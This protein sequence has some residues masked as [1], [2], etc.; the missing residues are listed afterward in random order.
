MKFVRAVLA[1]SVLLVLN[2]CV[3]EKPSEQPFQADRDH[4]DGS[5]RGVDHP[6][7]EARGRTG[8]SRK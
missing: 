2:A 8:G 4:L 1:V 6:D 3:N 7:R 5:E